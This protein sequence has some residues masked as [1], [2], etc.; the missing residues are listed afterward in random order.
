ML[1]EWFS[2][3]WPKQQHY[4]TPHSVFANKV[5]MLE[6]DPW[7]LHDPLGPWRQPLPFDPMDAY[8][9]HVDSSA[10]WCMPELEVWDGIQSYWRHRMEIH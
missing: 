5:R 8:P 10:C 6:T 7:I 1:G 4:A 9:R 2:K 3:L